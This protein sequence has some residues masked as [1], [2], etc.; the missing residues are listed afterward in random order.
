MAQFILRRLGVMILTAIALTLIVF[1]LTNLQPNLEKVA[2]FEGNARMTDEEVA[3]WLVKNGFGQPTLVRYGE[4]LA[5]LRSNRHRELMQRGRRVRLR[6]GDILE[7]H[8]GVEQRI[9]VQVYNHLWS[10][11]EASPAP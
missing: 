3:S 10:T 8:D 5:V 11:A 9:S 7:F 4:W 2:K 1:F 6:P